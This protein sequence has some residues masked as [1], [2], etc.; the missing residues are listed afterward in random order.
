MSDLVVLV[1]GG[2]IG[3][4]SF[5]IGAMF[6][7]RKHRQSRIPILAKI[8]IAEIN[9]LDDISQ[10]GIAELEQTSAGRELL[11][12]VVDPSTYASLLWGNPERLTR[13]DRF[14]KR[15]LDFVLSALGLLLLAPLFYLIGLLIKLDSPGPVFYRETYIGRYGK[16]FRAVR[17]RTMRV[18]HAEILAAHPDLQKK[19]IQRQ[20]ISDDPRLTR[21]GRILDKYSLDDLPQLINVLRGEMTLVGPIM[22]SSQATQAMAEQNQAYAALPVLPVLPGMTGP[23]QVSA[24]SHISHEERVR[25]DKYYIQHWSIWLDLS[26]LMRTAHLAIK[27]EFDIPQLDQPRDDQFRL[28]NQLVAYHH[29]VQ[30]KPGI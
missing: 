8:E 20:R 28:V 2:V 25:L 23:V 13:M 4:T 22:I 29:R 27:S 26:L 30:A 21:V 17:F 19:L 10:I 14:L 6:T 11:A 3:F 5:L 18:N 7:Y 1:V 24:F 15:A 16:P 9:L 12:T